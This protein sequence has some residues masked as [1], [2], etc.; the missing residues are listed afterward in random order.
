VS[1]PA[2]AWPLALLLLAGCGMYGDLYLEEEAP[3][4][5]EIT[6]LPPIASDAPAVDEAANGEGAEVGAPIREDEEREDD[7][8]G[9]S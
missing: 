3:R 5:P 2:R 8:A 9:T 1:R 4:V 7:T 6:E